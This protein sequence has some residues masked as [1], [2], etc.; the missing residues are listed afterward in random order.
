MS[1][2]KKTSRSKG[3]ARST[4]I[5]VAVIAVSAGI[6]GVSSFFA[7]KDNCHNNFYTLIGGYISGI[8]TI[9]LGIIAYTQNKK[10][11]LV[12]EKQAFINRIVDEKKEVSKWFETILDFGLYLNPFASLLDG[13]KYGDLL[14]KKAYT[15]VEQ[16]MMNTSVKFHLIQFCPDYSSKI[17]K[18]IADM[19]MYIISKYRPVSTK[20]DDQE[21]S[22][23]ITAVNEYTQHWTSAM[24]YLRNELLGQYDSLITEVQNL[25][26]M[27]ELDS[28]SAKLDKDRQ[29]MREDAKLELNKIKSSVV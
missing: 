8:A 21:F 27:V 26:S 6:I 28:L 12:S 19:L 13:T 4:C 15:E 29:K 24:L 5:I 11:T 17:I 20:T 3:F 2:H 16:T 22:S 7:F 25:H 9:V 1:K 14:Y 18:L 23:V 10:Y